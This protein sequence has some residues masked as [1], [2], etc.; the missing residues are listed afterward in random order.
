V[1]AT[2][3]RS[4]RAPPGHP[5]DVELSIP[6]MEASPVHPRE[7]LAGHRHD[8]ALGLTAHFLAE[9][10][11]IRSGAEGEVQHLAPER[12]EPVV[13]DRD[14]GTAGVVQPAREVDQWQVGGLTGTRAEIAVMA[15]RPHLRDH[16]GG[17]ATAPRTPAR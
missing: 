8:R 13:R 16:R 14:L 7:E 6:G 11:E 1:E 2:I 17:G 15:A 9:Q 4:I 5:G 12:A 3:R 10:E